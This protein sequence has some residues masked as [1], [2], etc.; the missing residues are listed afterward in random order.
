M[1]G[2]KDVLRPLPASHHFPDSAE[3]IGFERI[4]SASAFSPFGAQKAAQFLTHDFFHHYA[5]GVTNL[6]A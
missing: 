1:K 6:V 2:R 4:Q 5:C 3:H